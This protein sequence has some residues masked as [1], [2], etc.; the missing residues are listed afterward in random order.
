MFKLFDFIKSDLIRYAW[1]KCVSFFPIQYITNKISR[2][3]AAFRFEQ[4]DGATRPVSYFLWLINQNEALAKGTKFGYGLYIGH[5]DLVFV[6]PTAV[7]G[8]TIKLSRFVK[9]GSD[10]GHTA[11]AR[12]IVYD[13]SSTYVVES[14]KV[15][16]NV[17]IEEKAVVSKDIPSD[18]TAAVNY[19]R[20]LNYCRPVRFIVNPWTIKS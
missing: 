6:N 5:N 10:E 20:D 2:W 18:A 9:I 17:A 12:N 4:T 11:N 7:I 19:C 13:D 1:V 16:N 3:Q 8:D 15:G 14:V